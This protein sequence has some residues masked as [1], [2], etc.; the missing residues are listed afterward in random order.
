MSAIRI[1]SRYAKSLLDLSAERGE[2]DAVLSDMH[3]FKKSL[4]NKDL[5][6]LVKSPIINS[7][8]K[9][10]IF[11]ALFKDKFHATTYAFTDLVLNKGRESYLPSIVDN[12]I[13]QYNQRIKVSSATITVASELS[14]VQLNEIKAKLLQSNITLDN[15]DLE[16]KI[17][18]SILGGFVIEI[19]DNLYDASAKHKLEKLR[20]EF[21]RN[22][23]VA[24]V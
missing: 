5:M 10:D 6:N 9:R 8:K 17:D 1:A 12:F 3:V 11:A 7:G 14:D 13:V 21:T 2:L 23:Y 18:P 24:S 20:K 16:V 15:V 22:D 19:G 4:E